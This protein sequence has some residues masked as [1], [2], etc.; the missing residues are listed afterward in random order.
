MT[1]QV[2]RREILADL[3]QMSHRQEETPQILQL[4][5][6]A[7]AERMGV[8]IGRVKAQLR[9]LLT[10]GLAEGFAETFTDR[11]S[12]GHCR[13]TAAGLAELRRIT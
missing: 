6:G 12:D 7:I 3:R 10:E 8:P 9:D 11:A 1:E 5:L 4:D 13:I 2:I